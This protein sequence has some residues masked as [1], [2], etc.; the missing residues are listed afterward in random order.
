[1]VM[2]Y[3]DWWIMGLIVIIEKFLSRYCFATA[4]KK[5]WTYWQN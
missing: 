5:I 4:I 2:Q 3:I 1:M